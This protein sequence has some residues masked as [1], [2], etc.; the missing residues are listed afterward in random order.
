[1][2]EQDILRLAHLA[3][4]VGCYANNGRGE[5]RFDFSKEQLVEFAKLIAAATIKGKK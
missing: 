3:G 2:K 1:M 5:Q 4:Y